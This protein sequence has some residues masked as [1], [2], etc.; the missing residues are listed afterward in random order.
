MTTGKI[1]NLYPAPGGKENMSDPFYDNR[2]FSSFHQ[3]SKFNIYQV[4]E[5]YLRPYTNKM[6]KHSNYSR[7]TETK[8]FDYR[9]IQQCIGTEFGDEEWTINEYRIKQMDSDL[10]KAFS[11]EVYTLPEKSRNYNVSL[12]IEY[13]FNRKYPPE[14]K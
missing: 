3:S 6:L 10:R 9:R 7:W 11:K 14:K 13:L 5:P 12:S 8:F 2:N 4:D 1:L